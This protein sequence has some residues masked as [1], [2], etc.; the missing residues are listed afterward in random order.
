MRNRYQK[1]AKPPASLDDLPRYL[2]YAQPTMRE[3]AEEGEACKKRQVRANRALQTIA[4]NALAKTDD[5]NQLRAMPDE[6]FRFLAIRGLRILLADDPVVELKRFLGRRSRGKGRPAG[7]H[8]YRDFMIAADVAE[9]VLGGEKRDNAC[10]TISKQANLSFER[11]LAIYNAR[12]D[13]PELRAELG[14]RVILRG[15]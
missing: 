15:A 8:E 13:T 5:P 9:L 6:L 4:R 1:P 3:I 2:R 14:L 12:R 10:L 7:D 11:V